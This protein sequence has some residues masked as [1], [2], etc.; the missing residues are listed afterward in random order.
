M[1]LCVRCVCELHAGGGGDG[2]GIGVNVNARASL[3]KKN[4][5][6]LEY[7]HFIE[8]TLHVAANHPCLSPTAQTNNQQQS[9]PPRQIHSTTIQN[10]TTKLKIDYC[11]DFIYFSYFYRVIVW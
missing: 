5:I 10:P 4:V 1:S 2:G 8:I 11:F 6:P 3:P 7:N 9:I